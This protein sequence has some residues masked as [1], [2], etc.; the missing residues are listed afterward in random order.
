MHIKKV[1]AIIIYLLVT[2]NR[3]DAQKNKPQTPVEPTKTDSTLEIDDFVLQ[4]VYD[5]KI[6]G[7]AIAIIKNGKIFHTKGYEFRNLEK[8][9]LFSPKTIFP[10]GQCSMAFTST[11]LG[12]LADDG[13]IDWNKPVKYYLPEFELKDNDLS[14]KIT[15]K[16]L[17]SH[18][19][20]LPQHDNLWLN[21]TLT[22]NEIFDRLKHLPT[23]AY[24]SE[25]YQYNQL[26]YLVAGFL[27]EKI[28]LRK[29]E[30]FIKE[31]I[32][33]PLEMN[34]TLFSTAEMTKSIDFALSYDVNNKK[35]GFES[36]ID[37]MLPAAGIKSNTMDLSNWLIMLLNKGKFKNYKIISEKNLKAISTPLAVILPINDKYPELGYATTG[38]G[39]NINTYRGAIFKQ[40]VGKVEGYCSS[41]TY[42]PNDDL[43]IIVT[44]NTQAYDNYF[45]TLITNHLSDYFLELDETAW[46]VLIKSDFEENVIQKE[47]KDVKSQS[48][49]KI[50]AMP[51]KPLADFV[52]EYEN[53]A[54]GKLTI[55]TKDSSLNCNFHKVDFGLNNYHYNVFEGSK[56]FKNCTF[57][58]K[59]N[60][61]LTVTFPLSGEIEFI[62]KP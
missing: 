30:D 25:N 41:V 59:E 17:L 24:R 29:Y 32:L 38:M 1:F 12:I 45:N 61:Q 50:G 10:I 3:L 62:R 19:S 15:V 6:P 34:T 5:W 36:N 9:A 51:T 54:Y 33:L 46:D 52:G 60:Q 23:P 43:G 35:I 57:E 18:R 2:A 56:E 4:Q 28:S 11:A 26:M 47:E 21:T 8:K 49:R 44:T 58:F 37:A 16:D 27:I 40:A 48:N 13:K 22:K 39:W 7:C 20:G 55:S 14:A 53:I 31:R 42:F